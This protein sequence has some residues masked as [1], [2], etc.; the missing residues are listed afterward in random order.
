MKAEVEALVQSVKCV[1][2][3]D[4]DGV[5]IGERCTRCGASLVPGPTIIEGHKPGCPT[6]VLD[7]ALV[8][9]RELEGGN[10]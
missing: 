7:A 1:A 10:G 4:R 5:R 2:L 3:F 8:R 6:A 9:L